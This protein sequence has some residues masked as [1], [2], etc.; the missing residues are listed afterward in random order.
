MI[1]RAFLALFQIPAVKKA[2]CPVCKTPGTWP[3]APLTLS[4]PDGVFRGN[5]YQRC[6]VLVCMNCGNVYTAAYKGKL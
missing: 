3:N 4:D 1:R 6:R 2:A 5:T